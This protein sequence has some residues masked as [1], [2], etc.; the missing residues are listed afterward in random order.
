M[1]YMVHLDLRAKTDIP[2]EA[3]NEAEAYGIA[4]RRARYIPLILFNYDYTDFSGVQTLEE[5]ERN[6][7]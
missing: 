4:I 5:Y 3:K 2:V 7:D 1:Q 6:N